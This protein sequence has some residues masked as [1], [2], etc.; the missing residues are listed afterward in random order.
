VSVGVRK[1]TPTYAGY[2]GFTQDQEEI[3]TRMAFH[4]FLRKYDQLPEHKKAWKPFAWIFVLTWFIFAV[5]PGAV[6]GNDFFGNPNDPSSWWFFSAIP[7]W[8]WQAVWWIL[9]VIMMWFLA[10][11]LEMSTMSDEKIE[12]LEQEIQ[13]NQRA[14]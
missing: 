1:L 9:G 14:D 13:F 8:A 4:R 2:A 12:A 7:I 5:G 3:K 10:Y 6:M 11:Y